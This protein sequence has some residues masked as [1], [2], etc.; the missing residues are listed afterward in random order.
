MA[1]LLQLD[2][3]PLASS[4]SR[5]L[6]REFV[7]NWKI[8]HPNGQVIVRDLAANPPKPLDQ[9]WIYA[10]F[11]PVEA[12]EPEQKA[13]LTYSEECIAE[14]EQADEYVLGVA[15][16]NFSIPSVVKLWID[17]VVRG[18]RTFAY[19]ESGPKGLLSGKKATILVATGGVYEPGTPYAGFN[20]I[21]PYLSTI[22]G[23]IG[24]SDVKF[25]TAGGTAQ[26]MSGKVDRSQ[27]LQPHLEQV[28]SIA[29]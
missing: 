28:R 1:T 2:S 11:T 16:H 26:L 20:F 22:L 10:S 5:E 3:S 7:T 27:F 23:F 13:I 12:R 14:L 17:Q 24:V 4:V 6:T 18:G 29:V 19:G 8:A 21:D 15:M 25:V 9:G